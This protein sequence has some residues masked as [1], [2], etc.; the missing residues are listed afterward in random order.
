[1]YTLPFLLTTLHPSHMTFT[2]ARTFIPLDSTTFAVGCAVIPRC[3][4]WW[5]CVWGRAA[6][7]KRDRSGRLEARSARNMTVKQFVQLAL[8]ATSTPR[9]VD[10]AWPVFCH[11]WQLV[12]P[13]E[14][15]LSHV[16]GRETAGTVTRGA[17]RQKRRALPETASLALA[18]A[19]Q[20]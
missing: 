12:G 16:I 15:K 4:W 10:G 3:G 18:G 19:W 13:R 11:I 2:D 6:D 5:R 17:A 20:H 14:A 7:L 1:M 8:S 9:P